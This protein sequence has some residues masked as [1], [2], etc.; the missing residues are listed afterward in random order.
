MRAALLVLL[1]LLPALPLAAQQAKDEVVESE[2]RL[3]QIRRERTRLG[4]EM[5]RIRSSVT[6]ISTELKSL[7]RQV[8]ASS[9][10][11]EALNAQA[12]RRAGEIERTS[13][14][15]A[16][17]HE[18]LAERREILFRRLR[19]IYK[20]GPLHTVEVLLTAES[21]GELINR[22]RYLLLIARH[23]RHLVQEVAALETQLRARERLL[24]RDL[25]TLED[26]RG[27]RAREL[28]RLS[29]LRVRQRR[30]LSTAQTR[31]KT[32]AERIAQLERDEKSVRALLATLERRRREAERAASAGAPAGAPAGA[33]ATL[34]TADM[35]SL[36]WPVP[37][38]VLYRFGRS[39]RPNGTAIRWNG[40]GIGARAG[41]AV[42]A[43]AEGTVVMAGDFEGYGP[44]VVLSHGDGYYSLYLYLEDVAVREGSR[45]PRGAV[46]GTV[47]GT[48]TPEGPHIEFQIRA[49]GGEAVDPLGWL[50]KQGPG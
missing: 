11:L 25:L 44:T 41:T 21:F 20:R 14:D 24:Q 13:G 6:G 32:T 15:L 37:G 40:I 28:E 17:A 29:S 42:E 43:V 27:E 26:V 7:E 46:V 3:E 33:A 39:A 10:A 49:P 30:A 1:A 8:G 9:G 34:S 12:E 47:G 35:G 16:A 38:R 48:S 50:R 4:T 45:V 23:D 36:R 2:R 19:E 31:Q 5:Q 22:Y 18:R